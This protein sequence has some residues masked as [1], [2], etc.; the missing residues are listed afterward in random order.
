M[1]R[2][3]STPHRPD[4]RSLDFDHEQ[5]TILFNTLSTLQHHYDG[6]EWINLLVEHI[7]SYLDA[8][9]D[10]VGTYTPLLGDWS[11]ILLSRPTVY[12]RLLMTVDLGLKLATVPHDTNFPHCL[13]GLLD[14]S[15]GPRALSGIQS[16]QPSLPSCSPTKRKVSQSQVLAHDNRHTGIGSLEAQGN[17][18]FDSTEPVADIAEPILRPDDVDISN[19]LHLDIDPESDAALIKTTEPLDTMTPDGRKLGSIL[20]GRLDLLPLGPEAAASILDG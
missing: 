17:D 3:Y 1:R 10:K 11:H 2:G 7:C 15:N 16:D 19:W 12:M 9:I 8:A 13:R 14:G 6:I 20:F 5:R 18:F 4:S